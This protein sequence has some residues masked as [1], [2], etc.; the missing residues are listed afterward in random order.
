M[1]WPLL[2]LALGVVLGGDYAGVEVLVIAS[3]GAYP[4]EAVP[5][6]IMSAWAAGLFPLTY[7]WRPTSA[8]ARAARRL[9]ALALLLSVVAVAIVVAARSFL[10]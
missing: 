5:M 1:L 7:A 6:I 3:V 9:L 8:D 10:P 2:L 4:Q